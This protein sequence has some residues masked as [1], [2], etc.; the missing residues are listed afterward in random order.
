MKFFAHYK[1][2]KKPYRHASHEACELK[3]RRKIVKEMEQGH[4]SHEA[5]E[6]KCNQPHIINAERG[7]ASHEA[8][9]L[10]FNEL[11]PDIESLQSRLA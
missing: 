7:H 6:L 9:E 4:A 2:Q 11:L 1:S 5:C 8:C 10:K 3:F